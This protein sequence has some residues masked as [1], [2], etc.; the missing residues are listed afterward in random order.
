[1]IF[2]VQKYIHNKKMDFKIFRKCIKDNNG[3]IRSNNTEN[4]FIEFV[5]FSEI[6]QAN[7]IY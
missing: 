3:N 7:I 5:I 4:L 6:N 1:M 2:V